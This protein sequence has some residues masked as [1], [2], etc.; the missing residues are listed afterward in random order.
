MS[1][2]EESPEMSEPLKVGQAVFV[3]LAGQGIQICNTVF[4]DSDPL[5][6]KPV[7]A[8]KEIYNASADHGVESHQLALL[9]ASHLRPSFHLVGFPERQH[10]IPIHFAELQ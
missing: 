1:G 7:R 3:K 6:I 5:G 9:L 2:D 10:S 4:D 8:I